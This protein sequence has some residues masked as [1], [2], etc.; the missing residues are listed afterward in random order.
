MTKFLL[1]VAVGYVF[2]DIID[3]L[4]GRSKATFDEKLPKPPSESEGEGDVVKP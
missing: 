4:V 2:S 1:G 3:G